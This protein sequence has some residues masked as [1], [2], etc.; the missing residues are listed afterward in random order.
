MKVRKLQ[1]KD[2]EKSQEVVYK[3]V[4]KAKITKKAKEYLRKKYSLDAIKELVKKCDVFVC[5]NS[6]RI[7]GN[8]KL[9]RHEIG[10][11]YVNPPQQKKGFGTAMINYLE[12]IAKKKNMKYVYVESLPPAVGFYKKQGYKKVAGRKKKD[13]T[14]SIKMEKKL[15]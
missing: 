7:V 12:N 9:C 5:Q 11:L 14:G 3:A 1:Q 13:V 2:I 15:W 8:G 4:D 6:G 10:M